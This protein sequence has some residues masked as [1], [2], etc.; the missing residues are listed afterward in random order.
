MPDTDMPDAPVVEQ[1]QA[2]Q[3]QVGTNGRLRVVKTEQSSKVSIVVQYSRSF[4]I[5]KP[6]QMLY[7]TVLW[8]LPDELQLPEYQ[9]AWSQRPPLKPQVIN[10]RDWCSQQH[11]AAELTAMMLSGDCGCPRYPSKYHG[12]LN[13]PIIQQH[14]PAL[15]GTAHVRTT[16]LSIITDRNLR[17][18]LAEGLN[19][20]P[21]GHLPLPQLVE[22]MQ[23]V[24]SQ[25]ASRVLSHGMHVNDKLVEQLRASA[26]KWT[27]HHYDCNPALHEQPPGHLSDETL[28][29]LQQLRHHLYICEVDK[30][31][32]T[33]CLVCPAYALLVTLLRLEHS[34]D[35]ER[36]DLT[37]DECV[38]AASQALSVIHPGLPSLLQPDKFFPIMRTSFKSHKETAAW[39][40]L[41]SAAGTCLSNVNKA[42]FLVGAQL[43]EQLDGYLAELS[44]S[45]STWH[46][47]I[48]VRCDIKVKNA[49]EVVLN[50]PDVLYY[51]ATADI[52]KCFERIPI[53][54]DAADSLPAV[55]HWAVTKAFERVATGRQRNRSCIALRIVEGVPC[56][57]RWHTSPQRTATNTIYLEQQQVVGL[58]TSVV[59]HAYVAEFGN[60][61]RQVTGIPMGTDYSPLC[62]DMY[63]CF[64]EASAVMRISRAALDSGTKRQLLSEWQYMYRLIDDVRMSNAPR[65]TRILQHP[66]DVGDQRSHQWVY[67]SC[68]T[69]E[70]TSGVCALPPA[71]DGTPYPAAIV[72]ATDTQYLD[73]LTTIQ[74]GGTYSY[75]IYDKSAKLPLTPIQYTTL[76]SD[77]PVGNSYKL[78]IGMAYRAFYLS[79]SAA[80]AAD[81]ITK[82]IH[83]M[84]SRGYS[85]SRLMRILQCW[86]HHNPELPGLTYHPADVLCSHIF[87][88]KL[89]SR[90]HGST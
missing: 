15:I 25:F 78:I 55:F 54:A 86:C 48:S 64:Y 50:L 4:E 6:Q 23:E 40:Y 84:A 29:A 53:Q 75:R 58:L 77:R 45:I 65:M 18:L 36:L 66:F 3:L 88:R 33:P 24:A 12:Q 85:S 69:L 79:S 19:H 81:C 10:A 41:T 71:A 62:C 82:T 57:A 63:F 47:G 80:L 28:H 67:P 16:D 59:T 37:P 61:Y 21:P 43:M 9:I 76:A 31:A 49:Q 90:R 2:R 38:Q 68:V 7:D 8:Q 5:L 72:E 11:T 42:A 73:L 27:M 32:H 70:F 60:M 39:R 56:S 17:S 83:F 52:A 74:P 14:C 87:R 51:D 46:G 35:F 13:E 30:A 89:L 44:S 1:Q 34:A 26:A 20:I 22:R